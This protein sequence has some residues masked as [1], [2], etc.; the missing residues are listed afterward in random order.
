MQS[1]PK[2]LRTQI[3]L[4]GRVNSGKSSFLNLLAGQDVAITSPEPGTTTDVV[5]KPMELPPLG[6]V[7][8]LDTAG[9]DDAS[10]L[11]KERMARTNR[12]FD[13][14]DVVVLLCESGTFG[15]AETRILETAKS[16]NVPVLA[17]VAKTDLRPPSREFLDDLKSRTAGTIGCNC[18]AVSERKR[19]RRE[20][21]G[22]LS[23]I[24]PEAARP[25]P[26]LLGD[27]LPP[28]GLGVLVTPIDTQA[29]R[30]RLIL[31]QVQ[32]LRDALDHDAAALVVKE[33]NLAPWFARLSVRPDLVVCDSQVVEKMTAA[34]PPDVPCT[35]FSILFARRKGDLEELARGAAAVDGL[36]DGDRILIA[37]ACSHHPLQDDIGRIKIPRWLREY[38]GAALIFED[39]AGRD[40]PADWSRY[41]LVVH[42]GSCMLTRRETLARI[43]R[44]RAAG[45]P[46]TNYGV[47]ISKTRG[48]LERVLSP[49]P[50][51]LAAYR[52]EA[53]LENKELKPCK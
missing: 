8:F 40:L 9:F 34:T 50:E 42:C 45:V 37:E 17:V 48:V 44:A 31:P 26:P 12:V 39:L 13:R 14:A 18:L 6:P 47:C 5:E 46:I 7:V 4:M 43:A 41:K 1:T 49:F 52:K 19:V 23:A 16:R 27:L 29:P 35:T 33:D 24:L 22:W 15:A 30:G 28:G 3:A 51:A 21:T 32:A 36:R 10:V 25:E 38:T 11:G 2:S 53:F 20:F